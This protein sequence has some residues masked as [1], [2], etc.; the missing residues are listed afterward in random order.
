MSGLVPELVLKKRKTQ[1]AIKAAK[2]AAAA[3]AGKKAVANKA[4][5]IKRAETYVKEYQTLENDSIR[6][7]REAKASGSYYVPPDAKLAF[8]VRIRGASPTSW[9]TALCPTR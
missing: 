6:L 4:E 8:V 9:K 3:E 1:E 5:M 2:D 7:R